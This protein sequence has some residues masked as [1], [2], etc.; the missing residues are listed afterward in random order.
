SNQHRLAPIATAPAA[1]APAAPAAPAGA[2]K[3]AQQP[4]RPSTSVPVIRRSDAAVDPVGRPK[5]E[6]HP[7]PPKDLAYSDAPKK[8]R[9]TRQPKDDGT[10]EQ[11]KYCARLLADLHKKQYYHI[12][13]PFYEP[14]DWVKLDIP[15]YPRSSRNQ[16]ICHDEKDAG[17][18]DYSSGQKLLMTQAQI[19]T[20]LINPPEAVN[21]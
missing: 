16:W 20:V 12:A 6:I 1:P 10:V 18:W 17:G 7:P 13:N 14:V 5:R 9:K 15:T 21:S 8:P 19:R 3:K 4:R 11:L 2:A